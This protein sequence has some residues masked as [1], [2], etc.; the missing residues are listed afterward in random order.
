MTIRKLSAEIYIANYNKLAKY[1]KLPGQCLNFNQCMLCIVR[2]TCIPLD[3][4]VYDFLSVVNSSIGKQRHVVASSTL[5]SCALRPPPGGCRHQGISG[6]DEE[7]RAYCQVR[8]KTFPH[9]QSLWPAAYAMIIIIKHIR[10]KLSALSQNPS[11]LLARMRRYIRVILSLSAM[12]I[13][14]SRSRPAPFCVVGREYES[15]N[16]RAC[17]VKHH[18]S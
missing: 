2:L 13:L 3:Q 16:S 9:F 10:A 7:L 15:M 12:L 17:H 1:N 8:Q 11:Q 5:L 6:G 18:A 4:N 14:Y